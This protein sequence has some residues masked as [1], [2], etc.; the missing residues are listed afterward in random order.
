MDDQLL[1]YVFTNNFIFNVNVLSHK[2]GTLN[3]ENYSMKILNNIIY[4]IS[5]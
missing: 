2:I 1:L 5:L 3:Q 4:I